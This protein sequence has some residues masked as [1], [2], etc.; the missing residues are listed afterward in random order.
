MTP[1]EGGDKAAGRH[2][3]EAALARIVK[4]GPH[5]ASADALAF[6]G[7]RHLGVRED[8]AIALFAVDRHGKAM[9]GIELIAALGRV[10]SY[11]R[12]QRSTSQNIG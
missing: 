9:L 7:R 11:L 6:V 5:Q 3:L 12:N 10:V 8:R 4:R 1:H 2:D